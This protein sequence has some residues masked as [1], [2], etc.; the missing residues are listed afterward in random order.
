MRASYSMG[1]LRALEEMGFSDSFDYVIGS[2]AGAINGAYFLAKQSKLA[3]EIYVD[4]LTDKRFINLFRWQEMLNVEYLIDVFTEGKTALNVNAVTNSNTDLLFTMIHYP[5]AQE[6]FFSAKQ[7]PSELMNLIK[8][9][10][11]IPAISNKKIVID[12]ERYIDGAV[13]NPVPIRQA[14]D[15]GCTDIVVILTRSKSFKR[16]P[17]QF[18]YDNLSWSY[19]KDWPKASKDSLFERFSRVNEIYDFLW[20]HEGENEKFR[21]MI[22]SPSEDDLAGLLSK[23]KKKISE[24]T[25]RGYNDAKRKIS[26]N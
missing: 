5:S 13:T 4:H 24:N 17:N 15:L 18:V 21:L 12:G 20:K 16:R 7:H 9:S 2:S 6:C 10:A 11:T 1:A 14:I 3:T 23:N 8:A 26:L 25:L 19:F 22:I